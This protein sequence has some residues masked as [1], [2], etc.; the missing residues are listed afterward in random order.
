ML[1][2]IAAPWILWVIFHEPKNQAM[3]SWEGL[4]DS[5]SCQISPHLRHCGRL[6]SHIHFRKVV[7]P[8]MFAGFKSHLV[9]F[10]GFK[11]HLV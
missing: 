2:Y 9:M 1:P 7:P 6:Y 5:S 11:S 10:A 4:S 3:H 8:V